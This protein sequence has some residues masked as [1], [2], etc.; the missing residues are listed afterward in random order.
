MYLLPAIDRSARWMEVVPLRNMEASTCTDASWWA[1]PKASGWP[2]GGGGDG[3]T[4]RVGR[5]L[6][7]FSCRRNWDTPAGE[8]APSPPLVGGRGTLSG[9][10]VVGRVPFGSGPAEQDIRFSAPTPAQDSFIRYLENFLF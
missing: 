10:R 2:E 1:A 3:G 4:H 7:F 8:C 5:V 9:E 6:S